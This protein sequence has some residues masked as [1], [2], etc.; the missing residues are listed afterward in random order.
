MTIAWQENLTRYLAQRPV[1]IVHGNVRDLYV[2]GRQ[3]F[4]SLRPLLAARVAGL[5]ESPGKTPAIRIYDWVRGGRTISADGLSTSGGDD[6]QAPPTTIE[7]LERDL[8]QLGGWLAGAAGDADPGAARTAIVEYTDLLVP[9]QQSYSDSQRHLLLRMSKLFTDVE[10]PHRM[11]L[12]ALEDSWLPPHLYRQAP[13]VATL[14]IPMPGEEERLAFIRRH[15]DLAGTSY[16]A[17]PGFGTAVA[18]MTIGLYLKEIREVVGRMVQ[19]RVESERDARAVLNEWRTG[20]KES[21]WTKLDITQLAGAPDWFAG[22]TGERGVVG[23]EEAIESVCRSLVVARAGLSGLARGHE[24]RPKIV[25]LFAGPTG[26]GKTELAKRLAAFVFKDENALIRFDMS[27]F[28]DEFTVSRLIGAPPGYIGHDQGGQLTTQVRERPFSI[29][30]FDEIEKAN[31]KILDVF[32]QVLDDGRLTDSRGQTVFF[33]EAAVIFTTNVGA[34]ER[35]RPELAGIFR[36]YA[37]DHEACKREVRAHFQRCVEHFFS[38]EIGRPELL[39]RIRSGI[40]PFNP[41]LD[42]GVRALIAEQSLSLMEQQFKSRYRGQ[43]RTLEISRELAPLMVGGWA[44]CPGCRRAVL[45]GE[46][47]D[48]G[49][50]RAGAGAEDGSPLPDGSPDPALATH[51][52]SCGA[53]VTAPP[54]AAM[55]G[56]FGGRGIADDIEAALLYELGRAV[57]MWEDGHADE[58]VQ[59]TI[60]PGSGGRDGPVVLDVVPV[61]RAGGR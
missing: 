1:L 22:K 44:S 32:L 9:Y 14:Q 35:E 15:L 18:S 54:A 12:V 6:M 55:D 20:A 31:P 58:P 30:L 25:L 13:H 37:G 10:L 34:R 51:C 26:V 38:A 19:E 7:D 43:G 16:P 61:S 28:K 11:V 33:G 29:L 41:I 48:P 53:A 45:L 50:S 39:N 60:K 57:L 59:F 23:Q 3:E 17:A 4:P 46:R 21:P 40:V 5:A 47:D 2:D 52:P 42:T 49:G 24:Q 8:A 36:K 56:G 27:E